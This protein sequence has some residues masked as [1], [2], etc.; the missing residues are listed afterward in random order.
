MTARRS[1]YCIEVALALAAMAL[2]FFQRVPAAAALTKLELVSDN[3][4]ELPTAAEI[5]SRPCEDFEEKLRKICLRLK[6]ARALQ[7]R[8][9]LEEQRRVEEARLLLAKAQIL[10]ALLRPSSEARERERRTREAFET[11]KRLPGEER[12][13]I[14]DAYDAIIAKG[15]RYCPLQRNP[16]ERTRCVEK[17]RKDARDLLQKHLE[18]ALVGE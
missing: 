4:S 8:S 1:L 7:A 18:E 16:R 2:L 6:I 12:R 3:L 15:E 17:H 14:L 13:Q 5:F 10:R 9:S 11:L